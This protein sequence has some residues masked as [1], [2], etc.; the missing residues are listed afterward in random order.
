MA[1]RA[2]LGADKR[3]PLAELRRSHRQGQVFEGAVVK[4]GDQTGRG[5]RPQLGAQT[6]F[7]H[8]D[9]Y[10]LSKAGRKT[11]PRANKCP[12]CGAS[13]SQFAAGCSVCGADIERMRRR[14]RVPLAPSLSFPEVGEGAVVTVLMVV[15]SLFAPLFGMPLA[16]L[17]FFDRWRRGH[18]AI[19]V[20][21][22]AAFVLAAVVF[23]IA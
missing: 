15:V 18:R 21:A 4:V 6:I 14:R 10:H 8:C 3:F 12:R 11:M 16:A 7:R 1:Q 17:V 9:S 5:I 23:I 2:L 20:V 13:V 22:A 19:A